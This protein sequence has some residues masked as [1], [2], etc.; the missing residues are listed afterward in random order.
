M[1]PASHHKAGTIRAS[2]S[3]ASRRSPSDLTDSAQKLNKKSIYAS[4]K[5]KTLATRQPSAQ[6]KGTNETTK[7]YMQCPS[8]QSTNMN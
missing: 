1:E 6:R 2:V 4:I 3:A 5:Y 8:D 7:R